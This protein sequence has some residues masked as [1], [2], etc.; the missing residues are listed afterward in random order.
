[1]STMER[2]LRLMGEKKAS[3]VYLSANAPALIKINGEC[4]P[5]NNQI[6]P[7]D[8]PRNL[9]AKSCHPGVSRSWRRRAAQHGRAAHGRRALPYPAP[10]AG[11]PTRW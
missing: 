11:A 9:L 4:V 8:A 3:G 1:M 6:L 5:I 7:P 2:I 10:C